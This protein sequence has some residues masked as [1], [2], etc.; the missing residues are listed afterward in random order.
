M[1]VAHGIVPVALIAVLVLPAW[2]ALAADGAPPE[3][4]PGVC[5]GHGPHGPRGAGM[6][7]AMGPGHG[8]HM[9]RG[10]A[11]LDLSEGQRDQIEAI[12][13]GNREQV[14]ALRD[15]LRSE[16][17]AWAESNDP[18]LFDEAAAQAFADRQAALHADLTVLHMQIRAQ[19]LSVLTDEQ[20]AELEAMRGEG[21][22]KSFRRG[23]RHGRHGAGAGG[24]GGCI[25]K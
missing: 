25:G 8:H 10:I 9:L 19:V 21:R 11:R 20:R 3:T 23:I 4:P 24:F 1:K 13:D 12:L 18:A 15:Q 14:D 16:R 2:V 22:G 6:G 5:D 17:E 7:P